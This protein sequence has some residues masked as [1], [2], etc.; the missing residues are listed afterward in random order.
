M[1]GFYNNYYIKISIKCG[2][3]WQLNNLLNKFIFGGLIVNK[4]IEEHP[5]QLKKTSSS[6]SSTIA[7]LMHKM[8]FRIEIAACNWIGIRDG[9][10][11]FSK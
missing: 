2:D 11:Q 6:S 3:M 5:Y 1:C 7:F 8:H 4:H 10:V 9:L